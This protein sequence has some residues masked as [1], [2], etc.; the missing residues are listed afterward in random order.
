MW[1][2]SIFNMSVFCGPQPRI[3]WIYIYTGRR[4]PILTFSDST[5]S[6]ECTCWVQQSRKWQRVCLFAVNAHLL[7]YTQIYTL[8]STIYSNV[9]TDKNYTINV[10]I[11][12][13]SEMGSW[14][15]DFVFLWAQ[16]FKQTTY[17][18]RSITN[19]K[20]HLHVCWSVTWWSSNQSCWFF[21]NGLS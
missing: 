10:C 4:R 5:G 15:S 11:P 9:F 13:P 7:T 20:D 19:L 16:Y 17:E 2:S 14:D 8:Q 18:P 1:Y 6:S 21:F 3:L 12:H